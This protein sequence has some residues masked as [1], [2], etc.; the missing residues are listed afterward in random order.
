[1]TAG[2]CARLIVDA[3]ARHQ[4]EFVMSSRA[5]AG[6]WLKLIAPGIVDNIAQRAIEEGR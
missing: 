1:M 2:Q 6:Q 3:L 4:R 5:K